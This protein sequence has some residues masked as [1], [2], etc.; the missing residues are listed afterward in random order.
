MNT[1]EQTHKNIYNGVDGS[2]DVGI[3][4][5]KDSKVSLDID[6]ALLVV[7]DK[8]KLLKLDDYQS[9]EDLKSLRGSYIL[10]QGDGKGVQTMLKLFIRDVSTNRKD[11]RSKMDIFISEAAAEYF[12]KS[13][14]AGRVRLEYK[15]LS[16]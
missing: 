15:I 12:V 5:A 8:N 10:I 4:F 9:I 7:S 6:E 3:L 13:T 2:V 14:R 11:V 1:V 16:K